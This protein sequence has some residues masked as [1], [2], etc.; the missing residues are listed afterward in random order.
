MAL[1]SSII[2]NCNTIS[3]FQHIQELIILPGQAQQTSQG[4]CATRSC[5]RVSARQSLGVNF[6]FGFKLRIMPNLAHMS[7]LE[8]DV[9]VIG[10]CVHHTNYLWVGFHYPPWLGPE[11]KL[12]CVRHTNCVCQHHVTACLRGKV[13]PLIFN[14]GWLHEFNKPKLKIRPNF[15]RRSL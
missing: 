5:N 4:A 14:L 9:C 11:D 3:R 7:L 12:G 10:A 2:F 13:W 8:T 6:Q 1:E 15:V